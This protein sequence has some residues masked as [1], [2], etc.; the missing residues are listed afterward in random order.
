MIYF[1]VILLPSS[2]ISRLVSSANEGF[3]SKTSSG[4]WKDVFARRT[5]LGVFWPLWDHNKRLYAQAHTV[6]AYTLDLQT[7][8]CKLQ[9]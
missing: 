9:L 1:S 5:S 6:H 2:F 3:L 8:G 7:A 4:T